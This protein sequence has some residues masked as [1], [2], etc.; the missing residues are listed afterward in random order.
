MVSTCVSVFKSLENLDAQSLEKRGRFPE[1][2]NIEIYLGHGDSWQ[3]LLV[4]KVF[5]GRP[6]FYRRW[7]E[8]F[9]VNPELSF[10]PISYTFVDSPEE[11]MFINCLSRNVNPGEWLYIEYIYDGETWKALEIGVP[12]HLTRLGFMLLDNGFT[13]FKN[14]YYPEGFMEGNPKLQAEKPLNENVKRRQVEELC[15][16]AIEFGAEAGRFIESGFHKDIY[17]SA[18]GRVKAMLT[19]TC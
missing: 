7:V 19:S 15:K 14:W 17:E 12:P 13:W 4:L 18:L 5:N 6:P 8:V 11:K 1:E 16:E 10:G 9:S 2:K 3:R